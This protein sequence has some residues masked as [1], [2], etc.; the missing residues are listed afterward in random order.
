MDWLSSFGET[1]A[2]A[3]ENLGGA[4]ANAADSVGGVLTNVG[5]TIGEGAVTAVFLR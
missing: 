1:L 5:A 4:L 2:S 3:G